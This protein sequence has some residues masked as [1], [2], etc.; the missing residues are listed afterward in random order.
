MRLLIYD[1]IIMIIWNKHYKEMIM[2]IIIKKKGDVKSTLK[3]KKN[4]NK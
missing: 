4:K 3:K 2:N 1:D